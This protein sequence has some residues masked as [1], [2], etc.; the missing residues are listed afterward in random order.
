MKPPRIPGTPQPGGIL[1]INLPGSKEQSSHLTS[2]RLGRAENVVPQIHL[3]TP[4]IKTKPAD[5]TPVMVNPK[6]KGTKPL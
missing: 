4:R 3:T 2:P 5:A 6:P 1:G